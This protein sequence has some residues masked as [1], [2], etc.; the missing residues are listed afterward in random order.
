M[1]DHRNDRILQI[2]AARSRGSSGLMN[3]YPRS[4]FHVTLDNFE[5]FKEMQALWHAL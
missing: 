4:S 1:E 3:V 5:L 2:F